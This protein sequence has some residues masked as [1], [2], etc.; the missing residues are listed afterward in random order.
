MKLA[1][2]N[3]NGLELVINTETGEAFAS[4]SAVAR[5]TDKENSTINRYVNG[6]LQTSA[7]I[8]LLEAE[9]RTPNGLRTSA[10]LNEDQ[11]FQ[12]VEKYK[13][14]LV[15]DVA[16]L[17]GAAMVALGSRASAVYSSDEKYHEILK[18]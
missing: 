9:I 17:T 13:P 4:I 11:I 14:E 1:P 7:Q 6:A 8:K 16:T 15:I 12:V 10:L 3:N 2:Y 18:N 5:M